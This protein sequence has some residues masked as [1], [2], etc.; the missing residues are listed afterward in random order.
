M[1]YL[2]YVGWMVS[3]CMRLQVYLNVRLIHGGHFYSSLLY[4]FVVELSLNHLLLSLVHRYLSLIIWLSSMVHHLVWPSVVSLMHSL[5][6][7]LVHEYLSV[8]PQPFAL[9]HNLM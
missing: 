2:G 8:I 9:M 3:D 4:V 7:L 6:L 1:Q 5:L